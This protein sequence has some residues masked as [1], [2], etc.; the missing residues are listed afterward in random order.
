[1]A[2]SKDGVS[3]RDR[4]SGNVYSSDQVRQREDEAWQKGVSETIEEIYFGELGQPLAGF[5]VNRFEDICAKEKTRDKD[6]LLKSGS[7]VEVSMILKTLAK[8]N[9][10]EAEL[11]GWSAEKGFET[12]DYTSA[13]D[14]K[15]YER[16]IKKGDKVTVATPGLI[17]KGRVVVKPTV[18]SSTFKLGQR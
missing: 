4:L 11:K 6:R 16:D 10:L 7:S 5:M 18:V 3:L 15:T 13:G 8:L 12:V 17:I 1:M 9:R 14:Y 2:E